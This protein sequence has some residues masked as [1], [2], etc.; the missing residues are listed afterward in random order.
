LYISKVVLFWKKLFNKKFNFLAK[1]IIGVLTFF[2]SG[3]LYLEGWNALCHPLKL[4]VAYMR[5]R[6]TSILRGTYLRA[7]MTSVLLYS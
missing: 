6:L 5:A 2:I 1:K 7:R 3:S 4:D